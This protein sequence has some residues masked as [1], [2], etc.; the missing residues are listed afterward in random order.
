MTA[1]REKVA[2]LGGGSWG[3]ALARQIALPADRD[4][5]L[6]IHDPELAGIVRGTRE[7]APY[8]PGFPLPEALEITSSVDAAVRGA[9][10]VI[11]AVPSHHCREVLS[12]ARG[13]IAP[14]ALLLVASKGIENGSLKRVSEIAA[15][16]L[17]AGLANRLAVLSGPS[18]AREVAASRPT[19]IVAAS[20]DPRLASAA[21][22]LVSRGALRVYTSSDPIGVETGGALKNVIAI[23]AGVVEGLGLGSNTLAALIT[24][25]LAE[26]S[27]LAVTLGGRKETL[28]GLAG[29]GDLVLTCTGSLSRNRSVGIE[30]ARGRSLAE[31]QS[32][33]RMVAEGVRTA[34]SALDL[35]RR[36]SVPMPITEKVYELLYEGLAPDAAIR[37]LLG[38]PPRPEED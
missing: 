22:T 15:E 17:G 27:R 25:G 29:L 9:A 31:I 35:G 32:A 26:I 4:V 38:R 23:A 19:A 7:N 11:L 12:G 1:P 13:G 8:L 20:A 28:S 37:D 6:W 36:H 21:Q 18:F 5:T 3:T 14:E 33:S 2:V 34:R 24:R 30:I 16:T 10:V